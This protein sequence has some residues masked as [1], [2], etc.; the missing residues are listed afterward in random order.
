MITIIMINVRLA[1]DYE[2]NVG[3]VKC[4]M[5]MQDDPAMGL[6]DLYSKISKSTGF[7][8]RFILNISKYLKIPKDSEVDG[9]KF[10]A[11]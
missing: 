2:T 4:K 6:L 7:G 1:G 11:G 8:L 3:E 9:V 5:T 10:I